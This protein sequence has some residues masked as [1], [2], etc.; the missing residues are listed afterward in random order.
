MKVTVVIPCYN[1]AHFLKDAVESVKNQTFKDF[2][3]I[4]VDDGSPD[5][6]SE[7]A[8]KLGVRCIRQVNRGLS[9]ARNTGIRA[10]K[11]QYILPLDA[12]DKI[13]P[14]FLAKTLPYIKNYDIVSTWLRTFGNENRTWGSDKLE[15]TYGLM[16][17][18]NQDRKS[19]RLN[20]SHLKLSRMPSSA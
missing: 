18:Q 1:Q 2:E 14:E 15:P 19:T 11:G 3:I 9:A 4:V 7:V 17:S 6:T 10:A 16:K 12:D 13:D 8:N 5:N 20:S